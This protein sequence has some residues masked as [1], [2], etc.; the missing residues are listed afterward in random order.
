MDVPVWVLDMDQT[1]FKDDGYE[2]SKELAPHQKVFEG[3]KEVMYH[4]SPVAAGMANWPRQ[5][6]R[7]TL[8]C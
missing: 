2:E 5:R 1:P 6:N 4:L 3:V 8:F 7:D